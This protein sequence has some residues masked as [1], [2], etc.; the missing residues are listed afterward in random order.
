MKGVQ[1]VF[2]SRGK[3]LKQD[4]AYYQ[5]IPRVLEGHYVMGIAGNT[6]GIFAT[7]DM[8]WLK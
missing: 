8:S 2:P 7:G 5:M 4:V 1:T 6:F 3:R